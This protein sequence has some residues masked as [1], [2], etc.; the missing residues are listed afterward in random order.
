MGGYVVARVEKLKG[1]AKIAAAGKH[2]TRE[3]SPENADP[4]RKNLNDLRGHTTAE[5]ILGDLRS[6]VAEVEKNSPKK[7]RKDAVLGLE[8]VF[9]FSPDSDLTDAQKSQ[10]FQ[11]CLN[12]VR[13]RHGDGQVLSS[14][15]HRDETTDHLHVLTSAVYVEG[16]RRGMSAKRYTDKASLKKLQDQV[17]EIGNPLGLQRGIEGSKAHHK[18]ISKWYRELKGSS[19]ENLAIPEKKLTE[20]HQAYSERVLTSVRDQVSK[21]LQA[22]QKLVQQLQNR[23]RLQDFLTWQD[24]AKRAEKRLV[25]ETG[26]LLDFISTASPDEFQAMQNKL[27]EAGK[28]ARSD[29]GKKPPQSG[30]EL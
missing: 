19:L 20:S 16:G 10:Y 1:W 25:E 15:I 7:I 12:L 3:T 18:E 28:K 17:G 27:Q 30:I 13:H 5:A 23:P 8:Y 22:L 21:P 9:S 11:S 4:S 2:N 14:V 29:R 26:K 24:R 6:Q